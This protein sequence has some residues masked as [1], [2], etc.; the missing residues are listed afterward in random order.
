MASMALPTARALVMNRMLEKDKN[1]RVAAFEHASTFF[2][3][4][5]EGLADDCEVMTDSGHVC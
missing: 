4:R 3:K 1:P 5:T 2:V